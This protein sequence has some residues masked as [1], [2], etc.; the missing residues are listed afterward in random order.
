M[1]DQTVP[2]RPGQSAQPSYQAHQTTENPEEEGAMWNSD[3]AE[4]EPASHQPKSKKRKSNGQGG[5]A[6]TVVEVDEDEGQEGQDVQ[7]IES[8]QLR[9]P[10]GQR[11]SNIS[12]TRTN[13]VQKIFTP[14]AA[15]TPSGPAQQANTRRQQTQQ[16]PSTRGPRNGNFHANNPIGNNNTGTA[17]NNGPRCQSNNA[18]GRGRSRG[19]HGQYNMSRGNHRQNN[20]TKNASN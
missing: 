14:A 6:S 16:Q 9:T 8:E 5:R 18:R 1:A 11:T 20:N 19:G 10:H 17:S 15:K 3:E 7:E 2:P 12:F 4:T 13:T